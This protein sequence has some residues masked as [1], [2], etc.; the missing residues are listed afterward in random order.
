MR[1]LVTRP[2]PDGGRTAAALRARGHVVTVAPLL[3]VEAVT[4][5]DLGAGPWDAILLTSPNA[6]RALAAHP[7]AAE[8]RRIPV[9]AV[10]DRTAAA[11]RDAGF[12]EVA[13][14]AGDEHDLA[15]LARDRAVAGTARYLYAAGE[16]RAGDLAGDL[17]AHG[18]AVA[19][20]VV[21]RAV[22]AERLPPAV[23]TALA[24]GEIDGVLHFSPRSADVFLRCAATEGC[25]NPAIRLAHYCLSEQVAAPLIAAGAT[26]IRIAPRPEQAAL[27]ALLA[28]A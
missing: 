11:A 6:A 7:R 24:A 10:G 15:R 9:L 18:H 19:T 28:T 16:D 23:A 17:T 8:L 2:E 3:A 26:A 20:V 25:L 27:L 1:L 13:S 5:A 4:D 12:A 22:A 14:A 21:Y